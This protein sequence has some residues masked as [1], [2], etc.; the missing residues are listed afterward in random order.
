MPGLV[1]FGPTREKKLIGLVAGRDACRC[2]STDQLV[3][4]PV[5]SCRQ[6]PR[7]LRDPVSGYRMSDQPSNAIWGNPTAGLYNSASKASAAS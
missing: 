1:L 6:H 4:V 2:V 7:R 5:H 3:A